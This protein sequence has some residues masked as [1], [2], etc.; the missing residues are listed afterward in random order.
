V[1]QGPV[2][3]PL[4]F[5]LYINDLP[6]ILNTFSTPIIFADDDS[7]LFSH[8]N[9]NDLSS[10]ILITIE[11]LNEWFRANKLSLNFN[12]THCIQFKTKSNMCDIFATNYNK[13]VNST[14]STKFLGVIVDSSLI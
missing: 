8:F 9:I 7:I 10:N 12:T 2:L 14:L 3:G 13:F 4:L 11:I 5:L 6:K 1:P